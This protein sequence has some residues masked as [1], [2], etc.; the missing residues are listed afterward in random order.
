MSLTSDDAISK[1]A[2]M[3]PPITAFVALGM[4]H[5]VANMFFIPLGLM[6]GESSVLSEAGIA[7]TATWKTFFINNL[8]PVT[9]GNVVGGALFVIL[10]YM[11]STNYKKS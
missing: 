6:L 7:L 8:I 4:E 9:L 5:S 2:L 11:W 1:A 3:W 10:P